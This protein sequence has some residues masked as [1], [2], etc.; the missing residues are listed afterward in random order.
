MNHRPLACLG[1]IALPGLASGQSFVDIAPSRL[2]AYP[3]NTVVAVTTDGLWIPDTGAPLPRLHLPAAAFPG[4]AGAQGALTRPAIEWDRRT[5]TFLVSAGPQLFRVTIADLSPPTWSIEEITPQSGL[6]LD[7]WDLDLH[8]GSGELFLLDQTNDEVLRFERPFEAGMLPTLVLPVPPTSRSMA[9]D[10]RSYPAA[11]IVTE[12]SQTSRVEFD[13]S[14]S[15]LNFFTGGRGLDQDPQVAGNGGS[16][17]VS[18]TGNKVGRAAGSPNVYIDMNIKGNCLPL[19]L[20]PTDVEWSPIKNRAYVFAQDGINQNFSCPVEMP[21][22]GPNH[23]VIFPVAQAPPMVVP[24]LYTFADDSG[25]T[26]NEGDLA[27]VLSKVDADEIDRRVSAWLAELVGKGAVSLDGKTLRGSRDGDRPAVHLLA[28]ITHAEGVVVAQSQVEE[29]SNEI[30]GA[31]PLLENLDLRGATVTADAMHTQK[32][33]ARHLVEERGADYALIAKE[34]QPTLLA[35]VEALD[36]ESFPPSGPND[37][38]RAWP[39][40]ASHDLAER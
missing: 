9:V 33:L 21:A 25:I 26:G 40:R 12:T 31:K 14:S 35:D 1:L 24:K 37:R 20:A 18:T 23:I 13:G 38:Q 10:S 39:D 32:D 17:M 28:A 27:L 16:Y 5:D 36:W 29:K 6:A 15:V 3:V 4:A 22:T 19:A 34:N 30:P 8:P 2:W 7:L 11:V